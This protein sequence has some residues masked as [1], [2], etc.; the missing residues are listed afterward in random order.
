MAFDGLAHATKAARRPYLLE[1]EQAVGQITCY[2]PGQIIRSQQ[3]DSLRL[4]A[5]RLSDRLM[6]SGKVRLN[7]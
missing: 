5:R 7:P 4:T 2:K 3:F 6:I 1:E